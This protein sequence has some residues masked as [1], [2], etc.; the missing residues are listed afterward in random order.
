[1]RIGVFGAGGIGGYQTVSMQ[2]DIMDGRPSELE[3][4]NGTVVRFGRDAG[5]QTPANAFVYYSLLPQ[6][7]QARGQ[8]E[9]LV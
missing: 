2:R 6:E 8:L 9:L 3:F 1:M 5:V 4:Q 7:M